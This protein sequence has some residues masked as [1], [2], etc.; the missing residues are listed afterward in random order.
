MP[1]SDFIFLFQKGY[2]YVLYES[3]ELTNTKSFEEEKNFWM[4]YFE[5]ANSRPDDNLEA[6]NAEM[7]EANNLHLKIIDEKYCCFI[8]AESLRYIYMVKKETLEKLQLSK[9]NF[10]QIENYDQLDFLLSTQLKKVTTTLFFCLH[11]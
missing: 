2:N 4:P 3:P 10:E 1:N 7:G 9:N 5:S 6:I 11:K 8:R